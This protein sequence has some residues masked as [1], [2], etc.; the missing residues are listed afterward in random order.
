MA[1][2]I[3]GGGPVV[4][5]VAQDDGLRPRHQIADAGGGVRLRVGAVADDLVDG[6]LAGGGSPLH[7]LR[8]HGREGGPELRR[9]FG[10]A[11]DEA[12]AF[13]WADRHGWPS[14]VFRPKIAAARSSV[15]SLDPPR[16]ILYHPHD[17]WQSSRSPFS[18]RSPSSP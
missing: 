14:V 12:V 7:R 13:F 4:R 2:V 17:P 8:G 11:L 10:V 15:N 5:V 18:I 1:V 6:E 9:A 16:G 3:E